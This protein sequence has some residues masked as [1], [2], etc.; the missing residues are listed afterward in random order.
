MSLRKFVAILR[1][2]ECIFVIY[3]ISCDFVL[4]WL[5]FWRD[6]VAFSRNFVFWGRGFAVLKFF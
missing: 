4:F 6:L 3:L 5:V 1:D 2:F